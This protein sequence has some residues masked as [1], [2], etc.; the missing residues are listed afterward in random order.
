MKDNTIRIKNDLPHLLAAV[1][2][3]PECP[4]WLK[5]KIWDAVTAEA[6]NVTYTLAHFQAA[7][8]AI[9]NEEQLAERAAIVTSMRERQV[10]EGGVQ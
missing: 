7:F 6:T 10:L 8:E 3:H 5:D 2:N 9:P 4:D 1:C